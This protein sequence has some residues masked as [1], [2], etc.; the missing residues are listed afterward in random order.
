MTIAFLTIT[1]I[2]Y[3]LS[4]FAYR[5]NK[6]MPWDTV[7]T[8]ISAF[9]KILLISSSA[10]L[11]H[12]LGWLWGAGAIIAL[13]T[14]FPLLFLGIRTAIVNSVTKN[15]TTEGNMPIIAKAF[16]AAFGC[17]L[18]IQVIACVCQ[19]IWGDRIL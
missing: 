11:I 12:A 5:M 7:S 8:G 2:T 14:V 17:M 18:W 9:T 3:M 4:D 1:L 19:F 6:G 10:G 13:N 16:A 15:M